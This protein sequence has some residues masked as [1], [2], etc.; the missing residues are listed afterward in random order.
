MNSFLQVMR[1]LLAVMCMFLSP[2]RDRTFVVGCVQGAC[3]GK[4]VFPMTKRCNSGLGCSHEAI[5]IIQ[6]FTNTAPSQNTH[7]VA[8]LSQLQ[9]GLDEGS[10]KK[11]KRE[12]LVY[13][14]QDKTGAITWT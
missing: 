2:L 12:K 1:A 7:T 9:K 14:H 13:V 4:H 8:C 10:G 5:G 6:W 3:L 11:Q